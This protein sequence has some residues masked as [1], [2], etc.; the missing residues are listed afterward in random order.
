MCAECDWRLKE[1][2]QECDQLKAELADI[3]EELERLER[4]IAQ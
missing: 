3:V 1:L 4:L 2:T